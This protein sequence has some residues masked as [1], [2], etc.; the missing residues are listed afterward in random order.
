MIWAATKE[1]LG[2]GFPTRSV[3]GCGSTEDRLR[4]E[5]S[6]LGSSG[7]VLSN[8]LYSENKGI[9]QLH[10]NC[11]AGLRLCFYICKKHSFCL[12]KNN[13]ARFLEPSHEKT[14]FLH[15]RKQMRRSAARYR[16]ANQCL[17]LRYS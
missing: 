15:M 14:C 13:N 12:E 11:E 6:N 9:D 4:R 3:S 5:V 7:I 2:S 17:L 10:S 8:Y 16:T 1:I